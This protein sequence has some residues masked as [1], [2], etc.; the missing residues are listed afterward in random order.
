MACSTGDDDGDGCVSDEKPYHCYAAGGIYG[1]GFGFQEKLGWFLKLG[2]YVL[3]YGALVG[4][5]Y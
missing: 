1:G 5:L 3:L 4:G 2:L